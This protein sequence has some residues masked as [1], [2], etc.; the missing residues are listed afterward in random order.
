[1]GEIWKHKAH[2][3]HKVNAPILPIIDKNYDSMEF[4]SIPSEKHLA[5]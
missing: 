2:K 4:E 5:A 1:M 3:V